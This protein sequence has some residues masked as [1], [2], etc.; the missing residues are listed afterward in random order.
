MR[1]QRTTHARVRVFETLARFLITA[2]GI[3]TIGAVALI[4]AFLLWVVAPLFRRAAIVPETSAEEPLVR[5]PGDALRFQVDDHGVLGAVLFSDGTLLALDVT[6]GA[7]LEE[8]HP[9][10]TEA[11]EQPALYSFSGDGAKSV[12]VAGF[13][14]GTVRVGAIAFAASFPPAGEL[15]AAIRALSPGEHAAEDGGVVQALPDGRFRRLR[16]QAELGAAIVPE[17]PA[18]I[19]RLGH[20]RRGDRTIACA[21]RA[22]GRATLLDV[23][24]R[25]DMLGGR[26]ALR[27]MRR[28]LPRRADPRLGP[29][30]HVVVTAAGD[31]V[32]LVWED[33]R[34]E[35]LDVRDPARAVLAEILDVT[36]AE[37]VRPTAVASLAGG[38][39]MIV[40]DSAGGVTAWFASKEPEAGTSDGSVL[41]AGHVLA[42]AGPAVTCLAPSP[43]S[44]LLATGHADGSVRLYHV[45]TARLL[46]ETRMAAG[47]AG[48]LQIQLAAREDA[49]VA[50]GPTGVARWAVDPG[51]PEASLAGL[52]APVWYE[53]YAGPRHVWQSEGGSDSFEPK[54]GFV[55]LVYGTGKATLYAILF[56]APLA[57]LA[58]V[59]TSEFLDRRW[60]AP[61]KSVLEMMASLPSV[62]L[63]FLAALV[64]APFVQSVVPAALAVIG[65]I[66]LSLLAGAH[67]WQL[68]P[69][70]VA[71]RA[72][73]YPKLAAMALALP[74]GILGGVVLGPA[75]EAAVFAGDATMWLDGQR[76]GPLGAWTMLLF[77]LVAGA[78][79][80]AGGRL[81]GPWLRQRSPDWSG[82]KC[83]RVALLR[84]AL[85][86]GASLLL[87]LGLAA[88]L[89][90]ASFDPRPGIV[91]T[92]VQRNALVV[93]FV[94][95]FAV[96]PIVYTLAEDAL[97]SVPDHLRLASLAAGAT[98]WQT[99]IRV[100][101][102]TA[103]SG[104]FTAVMIGVGR[105]VG[106]TMI[107]LMATGN[108]PIMELNPFNGFRTLSANIAVELPEAVQNSTHYRVLFLAAL[109]LFAITF[110]LNTAAELV[111]SR[112]RRRASRL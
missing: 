94:M 55:P 19:L 53:G 42:A 18:P 7:V 38:A 111:R 43:R 28:E 50:L 100:V 27:V 56:G 52:F 13:A 71:I 75:L 99:A 80:V 96:I 21:W 47:G 30:A 85:Q 54:L 97:S 4:F 40:G 68:L 87:A 16:V 61:V 110:V 65:A 58:A 35:R 91:G 51:H 10:G 63:G 2:G 41:V 12:L 109:V 57:L 49:I 103:A 112:F 45:T 76:G 108:T 102:P 24:E 90:A 84:F 14:D 74:L 69:A 60:R 6:N 73:G 5:S 36:P 11:G 32:Y 9:F 17:E 78:V 59:Y 3:A 46:G 39:T 8:L 44:R 72:G 23:R 20:S 70:P 15:P 34:L 26:P 22:D 33:G 66:P 79:C 93:G 88:L 64:I 107:V 82:G 1:R 106:E 83:A 37:G 48:P 95:G 81:A 105:A 101:I 77:P 29:P 86:G 62:V 67:L 89:A 92:Y 31:S 25:P 98:P 104:L